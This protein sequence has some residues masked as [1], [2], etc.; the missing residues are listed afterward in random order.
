MNIELFG[1]TFRKF[2]FQPKITVL[3]ACGMVAFWTQRSYL[4]L[5]TRKKK[6]ISQIVPLGKL[7]CGD[8]VCL[9]TTLI[10]I[11][12]LGY[13]TKQLMRALKDL[14]TI[15]NHS[16][17]WP[18]FRVF[19]NRELQNPLE[20]SSINIYLETAANKQLFSSW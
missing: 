7:L 4:M 12:N 8:W 13:S 16:H 3:A 1:L 9:E 6:I 11:R 14:C 5:L 20:R 18:N 15:R 19:L 10:G 2:A 17:V